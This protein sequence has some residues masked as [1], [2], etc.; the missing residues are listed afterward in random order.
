MG[1]YHH[2]QEAISINRKRKKQY[3]KASNGQTRLLSS[4]LINSERLTIPVAK[5]YDKKGAP[6]NDKGIMIVKHDFVDMD[7]PAF[8]QHVVHQSVWNSRIQREI[9][10]LSKDFISLIPK[11]IIYHKELEFLLTEG[12]RFYEQIKLMEDG[13]DVHL[14]MTKHM[15]ESITYMAKNGIRYSEESNGAT[16]SLSASL[17]WWHKVAVKN[18]IWMDRMGNRFHQQNIGILVNDMPVIPIY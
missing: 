18:S 4:L 17:I 12:R 1:F 9:N 2:I 14:A 11:R 8:D 6:F 10:G 13:Y 3:A 5:Y 15:V 16:I 7:I